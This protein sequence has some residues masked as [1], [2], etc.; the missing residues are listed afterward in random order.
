MSHDGMYTRMR[1]GSRITS[2]ISDCATSHVPNASLLRSQDSM[3]LSTPDAASPTSSAPSPPEAARV[4]LRDG[5]RADPD[6][7]LSSA[8]KLRQSTGAT[9]SCLCCPVARY[10]SPQR[11][12]M[13]SVAWLLMLS[14]MPCIV[15]SNGRARPRV[16]VFGGVAGRAFSVWTHTLFF[17]A[18]APWA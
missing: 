16:C 10:A 11:N 15:R 5:C 18:P 4:R 12:A 8:L 3:P 13:H 9:Q 6:T 1:R 2:T 14:M 7:T 17:L